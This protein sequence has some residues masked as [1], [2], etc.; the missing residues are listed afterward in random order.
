[1]N[2]VM[3]DNKILTLTNGERIRLHKNTALLFEVGDL[4]Y[5]S[6]ATVSRYLRDF[7]IDVVWYIWIQ[8]IWVSNRIMKNGL[9][10][11]LQKMKLR[12]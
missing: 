7:N 11:V 12:F 6:P 5:A 2:S 4:H 3:D 10:V 1:M 8:K 9:I